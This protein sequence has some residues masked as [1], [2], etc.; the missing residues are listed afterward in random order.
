M[1]QEV[2]HTGRRVALTRKRETWCVL[3]CTRNRGSSSTREMVFGKHYRQNGAAQ[4]LLAEVTPEEVR[5]NADPSPTRHTERRKRCGMP[6]PSARCECVEPL[7]ER[8]SAGKGVT[9]SS[10]LRSLT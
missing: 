9:G 8:L 10:G 5:S 3:C 4:L 1:H 6:S 7:L 2:I